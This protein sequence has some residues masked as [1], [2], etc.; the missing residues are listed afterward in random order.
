MSENDPP[1]DD[2]DPDPDDYRFTKMDVE[3]V[4]VEGK[5]Q[6]RIPQEQF[7]KLLDRYE[8]FHDI[9]ML[10]Q[11][12]RD[13]APDDYV[14]WEEVKAELDLHDPDTAERV[15]SGQAASSTAA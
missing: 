3:V 11:R 6:V 7:D 10:Y 13:N 4:E 8:D 2:L 12:R 5:K 1:Y 9:V 14:T 15:V